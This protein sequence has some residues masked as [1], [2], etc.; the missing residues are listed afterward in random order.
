MKVDFFDKKEEKRVIV[1]NVVRFKACMGMVNGKYIQA[2]VLI[3]KTETNSGTY[4]TVT[5]GHN[6]HELVCVEEEAA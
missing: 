5:L 1:Y 6:R 2:W 4:E 3:R